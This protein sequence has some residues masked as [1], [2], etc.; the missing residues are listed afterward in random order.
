MNR[1]LRQEWRDTNVPEAVYRR[2]RERAWE[3][4]QKGDKRRNP[5]PIVGT[6]A[7]SAIVVCILLILIPDTPPISEEIDSLPLPNDRVMDSLALMPRP[8]PWPVALEAAD[9]DQSLTD[10]IQLKEEVPPSQ[11]AET[12]VARISTPSKQR[13]ARQLVLHFRL[14]KTGTKMMWILTKEGL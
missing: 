9:R 14:P 1:F 8:K 13:T 4:L 12:A 10:R 6:L 5:M 11:R 7:A 3:K 2:A